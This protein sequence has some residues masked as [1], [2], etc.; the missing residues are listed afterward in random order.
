MA[1]ICRDERRKSCPITAFLFQIS[2]LENPQSPNYIYV[3]LELS[4]VIYEAKA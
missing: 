3:F 1:D 2:S 4:G